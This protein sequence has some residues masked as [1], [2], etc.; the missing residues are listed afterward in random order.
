MVYILNKDG[1]PLMPTHRYRHIRKLIKERKAVIVS[2]K[3]FA[4]KL[5][6]ET[7]DE[8]QDII[9][10]IDPGRTNIGVTAV[11]E[12]GKPVFEAE[13][14]TRNEEIP[15]KMLK[16]RQ[17]RHLHRSQRRRAKRIRRA[18][19]SGTVTMKPCKEYKRSEKAGVIER[20][21][22]GYEEPVYCTGIKNKEARFNNRIRPDGWLTPTANQLKLTHI[23]LVKKICKFLPVTQLVLEVNKF[24]FMAIDNPN[25]RKWQYAKGPLYRKGSVEN[26][27]YEMQNGQCLLCG[28]PI[29]HYHHIVP[30]S[31]RGSDTL[32]NIA[33][34]CAEC[35]TKVHTDETSRKKL[36]NRKAGQNKKYGAL[37]ILNQII[38]QLVNELFELLPLA[39]TDGYNTK[40][41]RKA[42]DIKKTHCNDAYCI[43][44]SVL[45]DP[46]V[47]KY[48]DE[49]FKILQFR[50]HDRQ[51]CSRE[52]LARKYILNGKVVAE[53]RH[54][55]E[56]QFN[57]SLEEYVRKGGKT[58]NLSI[59]LHPTVYKNMQRI[60]PGAM[61]IANNKRKI[62]TAQT[63]FYNGKPNYY[64]FSDGTRATPK[65][66]KPIR[67]NEGIVFV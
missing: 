64:H 41:F 54:K 30:R 48:D 24:A 50:R 21:L 38:P 5:L 65:Q 16:R 61:M 12:N 18:V 49:V 6:Y 43:A 20:M 51:A 56:G 55:T 59:R 34:L 67:Q 39:V 10:G 57:D 66:C 19:T 26:A 32:P 9:L 46:V 53:N 42:H 11:L 52:M 63:G 1:N 58:D 35:H 37:S 40:Q 7:P 36:E 13:M 62:M 60:F 25:I 4:V 23:N 31:K 44:C 27:V 17:Y 2:G 8:T 29:E 28:N 15:K 22:P 45:N 3:P 33:G 14:Q 47:Q